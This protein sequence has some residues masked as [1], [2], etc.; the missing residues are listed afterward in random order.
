MRTMPSGGRRE[1]AG[2][3]PSVEPRRVQVQVRLTVEEAA[4]YSAAAEA[5][6]LSL[7]EWIRDACEKFT[8]RSPDR[9]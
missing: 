9:G 3:K 8:D 1:G 6:G 5:A 2:R 7:S 4:I